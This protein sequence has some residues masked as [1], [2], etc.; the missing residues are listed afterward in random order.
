[1]FSRP[2]GP[3]PAGDE[4]WAP[5]AGDAGRRPHRGLYVASLALIVAG[6][7]AGLALVG[8]NPHLLAG[9]D[10]PLDD[11]ARLVTVLT[12]LVLAGVAVL[13]GLVMNAVRS[14]VVRETLPAR[15]YRGPSIVVLLLLAIIAANMAAV[16]VA[17]DLAALMGAGDLSRVGTLLSLTVTHLGLLGSVLLF[18]VVPRALDGLSVLPARGL[19]R[20]VALG[21][22]LAVPAWIGAQLV[23]AVVLRLLELIGLRPETGIA[24]VALSRADPV[25]LVVAL[26]LVAPVV[27]ELFFRGVAFNAW[28][29]EYGRKR[30]L[31]GSA[32]LFGLIHGSIFLVVPIVALGIMLGLLY[33]ATRS[34]PA[35]IALHAGFNGITVTL[36]LL[37]RFGVVDIPIT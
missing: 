14:V 11:P 37:V 20:S 9:D 4:A 17:G 13:L 32:I 15:R 34:L 27:E 25:A 36:A 30:A 10:A 24:E 12:W 1:M 6:V 28:L 21:L 29:R 3:T 8:A 7:T 18:I 33:Q 16:S 2:P 5:P 22:A 31:Y 19:W 23:G 26:V 35:A